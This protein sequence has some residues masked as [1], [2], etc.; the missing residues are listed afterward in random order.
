MKLTVK[1]YYKTK[2]IEKTINTLNR[3]LIDTDKLR[4]NMEREITKAVDRAEK[5]NGK[6]VDIIDTYDYDMINEAE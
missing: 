6:I 4:A 2:S 1:R 5:F 3:L